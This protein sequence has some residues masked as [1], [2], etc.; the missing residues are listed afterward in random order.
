MNKD[1]ALF[2][3]KQNLR[4]A[5]FGSICMFVPCDEYFGIKCYTTH[6]ERTQAYKFQTYASKFN[7]GP[8]TFGIFNTKDSTL[9]KKYNKTA[10]YLTDDTDD[11]RTNILYCYI[12]RVAKIVPNGKKR[13]KLL[14]SQLRSIGLE[15][16][17]IFGNNVGLVDGN[18]VCI[19]F[20]KDYCKVIKNKKK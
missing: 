18:V 8:Q 3:A 16:S 13:N 19:D 1:L 7:L 4:R 20:D 14:R 15:C 9:L 17:D 6:Y 2:L 5:K 11:Y 12:T 10:F